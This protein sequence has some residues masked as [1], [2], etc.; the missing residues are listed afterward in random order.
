MPLGSSLPSLPEARP[1]DHFYTA[2][3]WGQ[4][5]GLASGVGNNKFAPRDNIT[6]EQAFSLLY[7][8]LPMAGKSGSVP[9]RRR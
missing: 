9:R 4:Q 5:N 7:R 8:F 6:R 3:A 1:W 2:L